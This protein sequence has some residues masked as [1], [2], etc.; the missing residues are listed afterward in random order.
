MTDNQHQMVRDMVVQQN[1]T[2]GP[3]TSESVDLASSWTVSDVHSTAKETVPP[4][5]F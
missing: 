1:G 2:W 3:D 5:S 4:S